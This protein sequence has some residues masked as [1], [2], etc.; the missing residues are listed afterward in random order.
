MKREKRNTASERQPSAVVGAIV[1][2]ALYRADELKARMGWKDAA[3][4]AACRKGLNVYRVGKR[5]FVIGSDI[6]AFVTTNGGER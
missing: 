6:I 3:F 1:S 4:R 5:A 2:D